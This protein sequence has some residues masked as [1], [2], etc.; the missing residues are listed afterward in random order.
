M[1]LPLRRQT[2]L[3][4]PT[5][6][7]TQSKHTQACSSHTSEFEEHTFFVVVRPLLPSISLPSASTKFS[8]TYGSLSPNVSKMARSRAPITIT[9]KSNVPVVGRCELVEAR[10]FT[11]QHHTS[12]SRSPNQEEEDCQIRQS[13]LQHPDTHQQSATEAWRRPRSL[14]NGQERGAP[15]S[16]VWSGIF[17]K[18]KRRIQ[19]QTESGRDL[20]F[21][22]FVRSDPEPA[23]LFALAQA[24]ESEWKRS[25]SRLPLTVQPCRPISRW[26][27]RSP[28]SLRGSRPLLSRFDLPRSSPVPPSR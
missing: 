26:A 4:S 12:I 5:Q 24:A 10:L 25:Q 19:Y 11:S 6:I 14:H 21:G 15:P 8:T 17:F 3:Y 2:F 20:N 23:S 16:Q 28:R 1:L 18:T 13:S 27:P 9:F 7:K 22:R